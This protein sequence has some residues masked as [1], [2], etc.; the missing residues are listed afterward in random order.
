MLKRFRKATSMKT[1]DIKRGE[2]A[3]FAC[4]ILLVLAAP[5]VTSNYALYLLALGMTYALPALGLN[6]IMGY[7][8]D[9]S[10]GQHGLFAVGAYGAAISMESWDLPFVPALLVGAVAAA[11][12]SGLIAL[13]ALR[14]HGLYLAIGTLAFGLVVHTAILAGGDFTGG[15][16]GMGVSGF[17]VDERQM[18]YAVVAVFLVSFCA[19]WLFVAGRYGQLL[20]AVKDNKLAAQAMGV[21]I[22][23]VKLASFLM[24]GFLAGIGGAL[25]AVLVRYI[26][27]DSFVMS[28]SLL[29]ILMVVVGG[30]GSVYGPVL[31]AAFAVG[32]PQIT[33]DFE[34]A[35]ELVFGVV[36]VLVMLLMPGGAAGGIKAA[37]RRVG[38]AFSRARREPPSV[39]G[40]PESVKTQL[41]SIDTSSQKSLK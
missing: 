4:M 41:S 27:S 16:A 10:L 21:S 22:V 39:Q 19:Y 23:R 34:Q 15:R 13:P 6:V 37:I 36:V 8:P 31:G 7:G 28:M 2:I 24:C 17:Q 26:A 35:N 30:A 14:L 33:A 29:F 40:L 9:I 5:M 38:G 32:L 3:V 18:F 11:V 1:L 12:L 20:I 25:Y